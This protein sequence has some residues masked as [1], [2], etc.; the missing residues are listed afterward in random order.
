MPGPAARREERRKNLIALG[1]AAVIIVLAGMAIF[2]PA[3]FPLVPVGKGALADS[4]HGKGNAV[5]PD[6]P[7]KCRGTGDGTFACEVFVGADTS[8]NVATVDYEVETSWTGCW[9]AVPASPRSH[10]PH[11]D[12]CIWILNY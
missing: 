10:A 5:Y 8:S 9:N 1:I 12:G 3:A 7:G 6:D 4:L 2:R 11:L